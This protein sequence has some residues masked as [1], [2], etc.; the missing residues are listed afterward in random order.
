M[1]F[2]FGK[3]LQLVKTQWNTS[4]HLLLLLPSFYLFPSI[5]KAQNTNESPSIS[6]K[7]DTFCTDPINCTAKVRIPFTAKSDCSDSLELDQEQVMIALSQSST[8]PFITAN[9]PGFVFSFEDDQK[10]KMVVNISG[11]PEGLHD[12]IVVVRDGCGY[13]SA[14]KIPVLIRDCRAPVPICV[15]GL[16]VD[17]M[18]DGN[19]GGI[20]VIRAKDFLAEQIYD[21]NG[22]GL[23]N[24]N[25]QKLISKYSINRV[26]R[27]VKKDQDSV[28]L[29]CADRGRV[30]QLEIHAWDERGN[31]DFCITFVEVQDFRRVCPSHGFWTHGIS[32]IITTDEA[33]PLA[34][35]EVKIDGYKPVTSTT[36]NSGLY[37]FKDLLHDDDYTVS[38]KLDKEHS[39]GLSTFDLVL[40]RKHILGI[41]LL[42]NPYRMLAADVNNSKTI[43]TLDLIE[44]RK[45]ILN[46]KQRFEDCPSWKFVDAKYKFPDP[47]NPWKDRIPEAVTVQNLLDQLKVDFIAIK[48]GDVNGSALTN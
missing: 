15:F 17:L 32:G 14:A 25:G 43:T 34:S 22:Q 11:L 16:S 40:I 28:K 29:T 7:R 45:L 21:C 19:Y 42:D 44:I 12:L 46:F 41:Q 27:R 35:V 48:M 13:S 23:V 39:N 24:R 4:V 6:F 36:S 37:D 18:S 2:F 5:G 9:S 47:N 26:A 3:R 33:E 20:R 10:G 30:I 8:G 1:Y 31:H 38:P